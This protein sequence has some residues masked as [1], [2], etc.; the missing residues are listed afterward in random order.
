MPDDINPNPSPTHDDIGVFV[1]ASDDRVPYLREYVGWWSIEPRAA[2]VLLAS[3]RGMDV[4]AHVAAFRLKQESG[5]QRVRRGYTYENDQGVAI[6]SIAGSL[7]KHVSSMDSGTSTVQ[8]RNTIRAMRRDAAVRAVVLVIDSPGG[9]VA[10]AYDLADDIKALADTKPTYAFIED[11]GASAGYLQ[12]SQARSISANRNALVGSIGTYGVVYDY[13]KMFDEAGVKAIL[14]GSGGFKGAGVPGTEITQEQVDEW[15][16]E[17]DAL[18]DQFID[19]VA[20]GRN[21]PRGDVKKLADGRVHVAAEA[22]KLGLIDRV[23]SLDM[24]VA[25]VR[26]EAGTTKEVGSLQ[27]DGG[28]GAGEKEPATKSRLEKQRERRGESEGEKSPPSAAHPIQQQTTAEAGAATSPPTGA[29]AGTNA[30]A[31]APEK[32]SPMDPNNQAPGTTQEQPKPA[33]VAELEQACPGA[34]SD[35]IL[36]CAK[37]SMTL[38]QAKDAFIGWQSAQIKARDEELAK[39]K[40]ATTT[41]TTATTTT[42]PAAAATKPVGT[43]V[44]EEPAGAAR[45]PAASGGEGAID[46]FYTRRDQLVKDRGMNRAQAVS[47]I[48][49]KEPELYA[50]FLE[51]K[52]DEK[53]A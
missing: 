19:Y 24:L 20:A 30:G 45:S 34:S 44:V 11:L 43:K 26:K 5:E 12:A 33:G 9:T 21:M 31:H 7:M 6:V 4:R 52:R 36:D 17:I 53:A 38:A 47:H 39:A 32:G 49:A 15:Q 3:V 51:A 23:E 29:D 1:H 27:T 28:L 8:M 48:A 25:R 37:Q 41:T 16:R 46:Q 14:I 22:K 10:G 42:A 13:S 35:F 2:D 50:A 40:T 18:N